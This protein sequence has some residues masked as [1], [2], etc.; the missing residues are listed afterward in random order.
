[1]KNLAAKVT[2][3]AVAAATVTVMEAVA[4]AA[5]DRAVDQKILHLI[6]IRFVRE[7]SFNFLEFDHFK[8]NFTH[9]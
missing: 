8:D 5:A 7:L 3:T 9:P 6:P 1:M 2:A 4:R